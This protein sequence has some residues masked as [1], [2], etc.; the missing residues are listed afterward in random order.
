MTDSIAAREAYE[1]YIPIIEALRD[2]HALDID[3]ID[4]RNISGFADAFILATARSEINART[5]REV[6]EDAMDVL[7]L[8]YKV[9]GENSSKWSLIDAGHVIVHV[10]SRDGRE[11]YKLERLW[12]DAPS[13]RFAD[14][15]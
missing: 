7:G 10:F 3:F 11:F 5:L 2:K 12:G 6:V 8:S 13:I 4:L 14:E 9:E 15:D 1:E